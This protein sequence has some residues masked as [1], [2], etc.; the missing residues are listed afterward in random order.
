MS[1]LPRILLTMGE[2]SGI[3]PELLVKIA[4]L[5]FDAEIVVIANDKLL[6]AIAK[7]LSL[8][9]K[10]VPMDWK[11]PS[12]KHAKGQLLIENVIFPAT[13]KVGKL[14]VNNSQSVLDMLSKAGQFALAKK[15]DAIVT[16]PVHKAILNQVAPS[17]LGHTEFFA[18]QAKV[19]KVVMMLAT[20][21]LRMALATTHIPLSKVS[22][23][24]NKNLIVEIV[25]IIQKSFNQFKLPEPKIAVCGV[26]PHAGENGLLGSE[27]Q[28]SVAPAVKELQHVG[29]D[30]TG[31]FP[32]DSLFTKSNRKYFDVFLAMYHD[33]GLPVVKA[34]GFGQCANITLG[35]PYIRTSVDHGTALDIAP[36]RNASESSLS[37]A[38][39][40]AIQLAKGTLPE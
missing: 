3:G 23:S 21:Q 20:K 19:N 31:P 6:Y 40:Y 7:E 4:Q 24:I 16:A 28:Q 8:P 9:L 34:I 37:Y 32:S 36:Q 38:I 27:D 11:V 35:L 1:P 5:E 30:A 29:I 2:P 15:V 18:E 22:Q 13:V 10:L 12:S 17:F 33:Q 26:N 14:D 39:N 25:T